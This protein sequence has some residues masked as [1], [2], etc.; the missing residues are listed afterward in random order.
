MR[1]T[2][3]R[4][5]SLIICRLSRCA[6]GWLKDSQA[7]VQSRRLLYFRHALMSPALSS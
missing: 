1:H 3:K 7:I 2:R 5:Q 4:S 6:N